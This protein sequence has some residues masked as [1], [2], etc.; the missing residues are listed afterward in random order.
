MPGG[1]EHGDGAVDVR[2]VID[3]RLLDGG[4]DVRKRRNVKDPVDALEMR[5]DAACV[6]DV[7]LLDRQPGIR[8]DV[9]EIL[10][11]PGAHVVEDVDAAAVG[12]QTLDEMAAD[13]PGAAGNDDSARGISHARSH[14]VGQPDG[15]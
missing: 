6:A 11:A 7:D 4:H 5:R 15:R 14:F 3:E 2:A 13:E 9:R 10:R 8:R 12:E 1:L